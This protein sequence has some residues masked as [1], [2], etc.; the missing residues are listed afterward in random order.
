MSFHFVLPPQCALVTRLREEPKLVEWLFLLTDHLL[1]AQRSPLVDSSALFHVK[2]DLY[3]S[4]DPLEIELL[5]LSRK[6]LA[7]HPIVHELKIDLGKDQRWRQN[8]LFDVVGEN[9]QDVHWVQKAFRG[10]KPFHPEGQSSSGITACYTEP[11]KAVEIADGLEQ[12]TRAR[13][14]AH[15]PPTDDLDIPTADEAMDTI[16]MFSTFYRASAAAGM[17]AVQFTD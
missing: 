13:I 10:D 11:A 14:D 2:T 16:A 4:P 6:L 12:I 7:D 17:L 1:D 15:F 3:R 5:N 8:Q 9:G